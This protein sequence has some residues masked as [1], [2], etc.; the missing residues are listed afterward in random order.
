V[1][2]SEQQLRED[3]EED[4]EYERLVLATVADPKPP[5]PVAV[6]DQDD[7]RTDPPLMRRVSG[8]WL[9]EGA[10]KE[11]LSKFTPLAFVA[12]YKILDL[13][14]ESVMHLNGE[15]C[16]QGRWSFKEKAR[17]A[18]RGQPGQLPKPLDQSPAEWSR[19]G[20]LYDAFLEDRNA[21]VHRHAE[22][23]ANGD[24]IAH[25]NAG[26]ARRAISA[27]NQRA[28]IQ[29]SVLLADALIAG[30]A[31]RRERNAMD[32]E[33][34]ALLGHHGAGSLGAVKPQEVVLEVRDKLTR[35]RLRRRWQLDGSRLHAH[36]HKGNRDALFVDVL[37]DAPGTRAGIT[38][39]AHLY[40]VPD[41]AVVRLDPSALPPWLTIDTA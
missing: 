34:D 37:L 3:F 28:F 30:S 11:A 5:G 35:L 21:I 27:D 12:G 26:V 8:E 33:L 31:S 38:Y 23:A 40:D 36:A 25:D 14:V 4:T 13:V 9:S 19:L 17:Y 18:N 22:R 29:F 16:P 2:P 20:K 1:P 10:V 15:A 41:D 24:L 32:W 39:R 7:L 6:P